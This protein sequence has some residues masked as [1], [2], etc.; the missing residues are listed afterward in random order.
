M[1]LH[2]CDNRS[3]VNPSHL[4]L[5]N[6]FDN[7][8]DCAA[9]G[10]CKTS[11]GKLDFEKAVQIRMEAQAGRSWSYLAGKY[12]VRPSMIGH[13]V[14]NKRWRVRDHPLANGQL[15]ARRE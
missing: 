11:R 8:R 7:M 14:K 1:V 12:G 3:C 9:K 4:F 10:R 5:G 2:T 6:Q 15:E 13:I